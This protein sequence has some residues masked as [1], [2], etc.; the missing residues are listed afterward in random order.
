MRTTIRF[1]IAFLLF[2]LPIDVSNVEQIDHE[3]AAG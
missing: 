1:A 3:V 2:L